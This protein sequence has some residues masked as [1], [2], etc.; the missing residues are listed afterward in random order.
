ML[1][2]DYKQK[3]VHLSIPGYVEKVSK[4]DGYERP[5]RGKTNHMRTSPQTWSNIKEDDIS[6]PL[7][8]NNSNLSSKC[9]DVS[10]QYARSCQYTCHTIECNHKGAGQAYEKSM[11]T[12]TQLLAILSQEEIVLT[13]RATDMVLPFTMIPHV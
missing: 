6:P 4:Q 3:E 12:V 8:R 9:W 5:K 10:I 7:A 1:D 2:W 11:E 13:Y